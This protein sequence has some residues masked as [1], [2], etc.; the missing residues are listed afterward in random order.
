MLSSVS[1]SHVATSWWNRVIYRQSNA[2]RFSTLTGQLWHILFFYFFF[3]SK[4]YIYWSDQ[5]VSQHLYYTHDNRGEDTIK[6]SFSDLTFRKNSNMC[7]DDLHWQIYYCK[8]VSLHWITVEYFRSMSGTRLPT[9]HAQQHP[10]MMMF[11]INRV[12][13]NMHLRDIS[14]SLFRLWVGLFRSACDLWTDG[15][16]WD[17]CGLRLVQLIEW[18]QRSTVTN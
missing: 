11:S 5:C 15:C 6:F 4:I 18:E 9:L 1:G 10:S 3:F 16:P 17:I 14:F 7:C 2:I 12:L 8:I 13:S